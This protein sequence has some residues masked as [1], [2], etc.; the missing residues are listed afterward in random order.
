MKNVSF[1]STVPP[2]RFNITN[3]ET[4]NSIHNHTMIR[5]GNNSTAS[6]LG[7]KVQNND[8][9]NDIAGYDD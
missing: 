4:N 9:K 8:S 2:M 1:S 5:N 7:N 3:R 6:M